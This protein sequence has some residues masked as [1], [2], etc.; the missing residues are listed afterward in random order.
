MTRYIKLKKLYA[1]KAKLLKKKRHTQ[2]DHKILMEIHREIGGLESIIR[3]RDDYIQEF[4]L[5]LVTEFEKWQTMNSTYGE[6]VISP[7]YTF[8]HFRDYFK[9]I[10][11]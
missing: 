11:G 10:G 9:K 5:K 1:K 8:L 3:D 7:F 4:G 2:A 6:T